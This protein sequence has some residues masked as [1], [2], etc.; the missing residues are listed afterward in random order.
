MYIVIDGYNLIKQLYNVNKISEKKRD[1]YVEKLINKADDKGHSLVIVFDG[2]EYGFPTK[3]QRNNHLILYSGYKESADD[4]IK[5]YVADHRNLELIVVTSDRE[6]RDFV[7]N[8]GVD[9]IGSPG[10]DKL[11][12]QDRPDASSTVSI[13]RHAR[14]IKMGDGSDPEL[15]ELMAG[16]AG[17]S[18]VKDDSE[19]ESRQSGARKES[20]KEK[21]MRKKLAKL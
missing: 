19:K 8:L 2:G 5:Q 18:V 3:E 1:N 6:I 11:F 12:S 16:V 17:E 7:H 21:K 15:D 10:F 9:T 14:T 4:V 13:S 20:K